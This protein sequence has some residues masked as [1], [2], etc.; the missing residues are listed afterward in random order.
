MATV[1]LTG[2]TGYV[3]GRLAPRLLESGHTVRCLARDPNRLQGRAWRDRVE[4]V[5]GD[6]L[7]PETLAG[8]FEGVHTAY[9]LVHT[10]Q[11]GHGFHERDL[12]CA[13]NFARAAKEAGVQRIVYLGALGRS[14]D[15][16]LS[17]HLRSRQQVADELRAH[18]PHLIEFRAGVIVGSG[19]LSFELIRDL[20]ERLPVMICPRWVYTRAQPIAIR[21]VLSYLVAAIDVEAGSHVVEIGGAQRLSYGDMM[22]GYARARG[23]KR[24]MIPVPVLTPRLSS[25]WVHFVTPVPASIARP[26]I[27][28]LRNEVVADTSEARRLFPHVEPMTYDEALQRALRRLHD[29]VLDTTWCDSLSSSVSGRPVELKVTEGMIVE[30]RVRR[31]SAPPSAVFA[32]FSSLGGERGW[33]YL[34]WTWQVRGIID[35]LLGGV[36]MRRGRRHP[37]T[38]RVGDALD[39]WRVEAVEPE[40]LVRLRAEMKVPGRAWLQFEVVP[41]EGGSELRQTAFFAPRGLAGFVY[42]YALYPV[43]GFIFG[44]LVDGIG[45]LS[46]KMR[47][48]PPDATA[49][50][51]V[52]VG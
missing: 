19:S 7:R 31:V 49:N 15:A 21:D 26:L 37:D 6:A 17:T 50:V 27:E 13:R 10:M 12:A 8:A 2:A 9:F 28:G 22:K 29:H 34:D 16:S 45:R 39:F 36:G 4:V 32:A 41:A 46:L 25:Y 20:T 33:L 23:L 44:G 30:R 48:T 51:P 52:R 1:L 40:R 38:L 5:Q 3:G 35:R 14:D 42:W 43:H 47:S 24:L 18:G 11:G